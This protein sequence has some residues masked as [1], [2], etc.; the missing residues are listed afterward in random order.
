[1][2]TARLL[3]G[4]VRTVLRAL[5]T[6]Y[7]DCVVLD[8]FGGAGTVGLVAAGFGLDCTLIEI[9]PSDVEMAA[10]RIRAGVSSAVVIVDSENVS[11]A[12]CEPSS[13]D[14]AHANAD[15]PHAPAA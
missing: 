4:D 1:M 5:P 6:A 15:P 10:A 3:T 11:R 13:T 7:F 8:P 14:A 12:L 9:K 2:S